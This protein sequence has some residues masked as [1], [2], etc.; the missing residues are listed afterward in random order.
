MAVSIADFG[1]GSVKRLLMAGLLVFVSGH[2]AFGSVGLELELTDGTNTALINSAGTLV[3]TGSASGTASANLALG[4][5]SFNGSV[6]NYLV[7]VSTGEGSPLLPMG[8]LD[9]NSVDTSGSSSG[10]LKIWWS[11]NGLTTA[12]SGW[13]MQWGG[14]L[15]SGAG[16]NVSDTA[17][18]DNTNAFFG[19]QNTIGSIGPQGPGVVGGTAGSGVAVSTPYSLSELITLNGVGTTNYSGDASMSP[20]PEPAS[21]VLF[22]GVVLAIATALRRKVIN[23][24]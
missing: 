14:T 8:N 16:A 22:G 11:E 19:T 24:A 20:V 12:Y 15:S 23:Q 6:G 17:Y 13:L 9:L 5:F 18:E 21:A 1:G 2:F 10:P 3:L 4:V 7:N